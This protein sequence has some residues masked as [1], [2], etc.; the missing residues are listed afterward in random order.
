MKMEH[1]KRYA[2]TI[3]PLTH[4][5]CTLFLLFSIFYTI[6]AS[7]FDYKDAL[8]KTLLYFEA[9]RS[10]R[11]PYDQR[12]SWRHHSGLADGLQQGV[13]YVYYEYV[14][15]KYYK[16]VSDVYQLLQKKNI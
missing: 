8:S 6:R 11:L 3:K 12:V 16:K 15:K 2:N 7:H 5:H 14:F 1:N 4:L 13:C 9:Q 10:G